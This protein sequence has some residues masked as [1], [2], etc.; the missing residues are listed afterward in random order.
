MKVTE[1]ARRQSR[2]LASLREKVLQYLEDHADEV[3]SYRDEQLAGALGV[4]ISALSFTLWALHR[5]GLIDKAQ[6]NGKTYFG[7]RRAVAELGRRLGF[8]RQDP[9]ERAATLRER[10]SA[11]T[12]GVDVIELLDG[13][14]GAWE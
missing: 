8:T 11:R 14:R 12:G 2:G 1:L 9:F 13:V 7:S 3:F 10:I 6:A 5:D 4:K